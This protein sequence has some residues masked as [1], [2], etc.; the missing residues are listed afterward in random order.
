MSELTLASVEDAFQQWHAGRYSLAEPIPE[1]LWSMALGL[2]PR[3]NR[4]KICHLLHRSGAQMKR[5]LE[6]IIDRRRH[7]GFV[8]ASRNEAKTSPMPN[9]EVQLTI[10]G[11]ERALTFYIGMHALGDILPHVVALL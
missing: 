3:Y 5:R 1:V 11:K 7:N 6:D 2:Y 9:P 4:S 8:V 10:Q